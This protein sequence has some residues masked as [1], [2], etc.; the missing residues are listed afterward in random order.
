MKGLDQGGEKGV[1]IDPR[2]T[3][4]LC[5]SVFVI[6]ERFIEKVVT[7]VGVVSGGV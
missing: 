6:E 7:G 5:V 3:Q 4:A 1:R 2:Q